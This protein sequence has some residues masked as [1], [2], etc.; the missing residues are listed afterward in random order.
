VLRAAALILACAALAACASERFGQT[1][2]EA[3]TGSAAQAPAQPPPPDM[4]GRWTLSAG[5][6]QC[7]MSFNARPGV[8]E[9]TVAPE[10]GCPGEFFTSRKWTLDRSN[11]VIRNHKDEPLAQLS[12][13]DPRSFQGKSNNGETITLSR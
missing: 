4:T 7:G 6:G 2:P 10:G 13:A 12:V 9:G 5:R 8:S 1:G 11:L 3:T